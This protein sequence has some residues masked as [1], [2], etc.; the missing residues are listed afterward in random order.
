MICQILL[1]TTEYTAHPDRYPSSMETRLEVWIDGDCAVCR[2]SQRWCAARDHDRRLS[3]TDLHSA[4][5]VEPPADR[6]DMLREV[7][8]RRPDG[9]VATGY[10]GWLLVLS[11]L[12][13]WSR[14]AAV[15]SWSPLRRIGPF[16]YALVA[17]S[18]HRLSRIIKG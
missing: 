5:G 12:P 2:R 7:H 6:E 10:D 17:K 11:E 16:F 3:F 18:R 13:G 1:T 9:S 4:G 14:L 15:A 8:V